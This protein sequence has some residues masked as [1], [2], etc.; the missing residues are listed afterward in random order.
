MIHVDAPTRAARHAA[1]RRWLIAND[2]ALANGRSTVAGAFSLYEGETDADLHVRPWTFRL[3]MMQ[4][5]CCGDLRAWRG[6]RPA[7]EPTPML[8]F[9]RMS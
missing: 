5:R 4:L 8:P 3:L 6:R 9:G 1:V 2:I 7:S